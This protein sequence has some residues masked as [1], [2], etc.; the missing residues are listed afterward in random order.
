MNFF[1]KVIGKSL[2]ILRMVKVVSK[3]NYI[4]ISS[5]K[6]LI[7]CIVPGNPLTSHFT[8]RQNDL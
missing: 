7:P 4:Y 2:F 3:N 6:E 8:S 1:K 5:Q